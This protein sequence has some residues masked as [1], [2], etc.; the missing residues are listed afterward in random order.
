M[1]VPRR[2]DA[3]ESSIHAGY[4]PGGPRPLS[5]GGITI[6][7]LAW[8]SAPTECDR[9]IAALSPSTTPN[10]TRGIGEAGTVSPSTL[11]VLIVLSACGFRNA[12]TITGR[13]TNAYETNA[14]TG[15]PGSHAIGVPSTFPHA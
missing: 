10:I 8:A 6:T 11:T 3:T 7:Q 15:F 9:M 14:Q 12:A 1:Q 13:T 4:S 5:E 2:V